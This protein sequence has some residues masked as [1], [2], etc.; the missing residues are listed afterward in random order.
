MQICLGSSSWIQQLDYESLP[1]RCRFCH[2]YSHLLR[3]CP[4][5]RK[6]ANPPSSAPPPLGKEDKGKAPM[7]AEPQGKDK[8]GFVPLN[9]KAK[10]RGQ[11][12]SFKDSQTD[13]SFKRFEGL[14]NFALE[15]GVPHVVTSNCVGVSMEVV[16]VI[17]LEP[18]QAIQE[19][20]VA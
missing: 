1:F 16:L 13:G 3:H 2:E 7:I 8:K 18:I 4:K 14:E 17:E 15:E 5:V 10:G 19:Q 11:K 6:D 12:R 9:T 20:Q